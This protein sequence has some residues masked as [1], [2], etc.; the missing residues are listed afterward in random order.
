MQC[1]S[2]ADETH[3]WLIEAKMLNQ[4]FHSCTLLV[5]SGLKVVLIKI[6]PF[7]NLV[8]LTSH[9]N[10]NRSI[11]IIAHLRDLD[12]TLRH[13]VSLNFS[14]YVSALVSDIS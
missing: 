5:F 2:S 3:L 1:D 7:Y 12:K 13:S 11:L 8:A 9:V 10:D 4:M 6:F 14:W